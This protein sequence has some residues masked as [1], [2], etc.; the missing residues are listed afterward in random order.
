[1]FEVYFYASILN[2][3][4]EIKILIYAKQINPV[5]SQIT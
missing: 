3:K 4:H 2:Q 5:T 1:M